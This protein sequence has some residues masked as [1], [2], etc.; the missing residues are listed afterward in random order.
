M[1]PNSLRLPYFAS[2]FFSFFSRKGAETC[3]PRRTGAKK[4]RSLISCYSLLACLTAGGLGVLAA[5]RAKYFFSFSLAK[6]QSLPSVGH[7]RQ[8]KR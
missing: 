1:V 2:Y 5:L 7:S 4:C 8:A 6:T 3:P